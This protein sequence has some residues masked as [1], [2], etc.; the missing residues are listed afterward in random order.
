M[1][2]CFFGGPC[3]DWIVRWLSIRNKGQFEPEYRLWCMIG[4]LIFGPIGLMLWGG[5]LGSQLSLYTAIAGTGITYAVVCAVATI[6]ITYM[7]DSYKPLSADTIT[8]LQI[9]RGIFAYA[10]SFAVTPWTM[11]S[12]YIKMSGYMTLIE[13]VVFLMT[14][15]LYVYGARIRQWTIKK[16]N[17]Y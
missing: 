4:P 9:F 8:V 15:P 3:S 11:N 13:G 5:A 6:G 12:G 17:L 1:L 10:V 16:F 14:I 2:G 7:V